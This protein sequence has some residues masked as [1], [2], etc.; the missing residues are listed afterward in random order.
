MIVGGP[1]T[2]EICKNEI[3]GVDVYVSDVNSV[4]QTT[5]QFA[6][7]IFSVEEHSHLGGRLLKWKGQTN[8][9]ILQSPTLDL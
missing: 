8:Y 7:L 5:K 1:W 2:Y 3:F 4:V 9:E 6:V